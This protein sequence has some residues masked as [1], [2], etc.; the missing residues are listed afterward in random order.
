M[1]QVK[2]QTYFNVT[3]FLENSVSIKAVQKY[4]FRGYIMLGF[5]VV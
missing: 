4:V 2:V 1:I 3:P 5:I